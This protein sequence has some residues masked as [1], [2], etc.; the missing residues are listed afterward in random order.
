MGDI[1][2][3]AKT[4][5]QPQQDTRDP[6][7]LKAAQLYE[8]QFLREMVRAMRKTVSESELMPASMGEKIFRNQ[9]DDE[10][11][12]QWVGKGGVGL[13]DLIYN[14]IK[15][16]YGNQF[17]MKNIKPLDRPRGPL[18]EDLKQNIKIKKNGDGKVDQFSFY[19]NKELD[20]KTLE[21]LSPWSGKVQSSF[22]SPEGLSIVKLDHDNGTQSTLAFNGAVSS[23]PPDTKVAPGDRIGRFSAEKPLIW[24]INYSPVS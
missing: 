14:Q 11:V 24:S 12:D 10:Y 15:E 5:P 20:K 4:Q 23:L 16:R 19:I 17:G 18:P 22:Q 1:S 6:K 3:I 7:L 9:L 21:I 13:S 8:S 2:S